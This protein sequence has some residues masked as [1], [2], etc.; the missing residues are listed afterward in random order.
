MSGGNGRGVPSYDDLVQEVEELRAENGRLRELLGFEERVSDGH[1][2]AWAPTLLDESSERPAV[3]ASSS[4]ADKLAL[5]WSLFGARSDVYARR[6][7]N[8]ST[9]KSGWSPATKGRWSKGRAPKDY[10]PVT[11]DV[12]ASHLRGNQSI[13]IYPLLRGDTCACWRATSTRALGHSTRSPTSMP[14]I[15][16]PYQ[17]RWSGP[18]PGTGHTC[19]PSSSHP[20]RR[21]QL[22]RWVPRCCAKR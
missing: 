17:Q 5:F 13:G 7:E 20:S 12:F 19:G 16:T 1:V 8:T 6:W 14:A 21:R 15:A 11:D 10:L 9:G 4:R 3:D 2:Q 22:V 18:G